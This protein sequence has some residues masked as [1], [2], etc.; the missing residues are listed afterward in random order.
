M[1]DIELPVTWTIDGLKEA[2]VDFVFSESWTEVA[3]VSCYAEL[4]SS[5]VA[6]SRNVSLAH[7]SASGLYVGRYPASIT[8]IENSLVAVT[9]APSATDLFLIGNVGSYAYVGITSGPSLI[10]PGDVL[11]LNGHGQLAGDV[12]IR[13]RIR[14]DDGYDSTNQ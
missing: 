5:A 11:R 8:Y 4:Q 2:T 6:G 12:A 10:S 1:R 3:I 13:W 9:W 14:V 7:L